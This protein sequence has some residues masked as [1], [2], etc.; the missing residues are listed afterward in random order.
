[1]INWDVIL[2]L[3]VFFLKFSAA[4]WATINKDLDPLIIAVL[5]ISGIFW[6]LFAVFLV[7]Q[8]N[9]KHLRINSQPH[10]SS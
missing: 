10:L 4:I 1:M 2:P 6:L 7:K 5:Y 9:K 8:K 3:L